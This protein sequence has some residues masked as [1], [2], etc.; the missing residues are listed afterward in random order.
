MIV[1]TGGH[2]KNFNDRTGYQKGKFHTLNLT[3]ST[4][5]CGIQI[6]IENS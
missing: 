4:Y 1:L 2:Q 3:N 6:L 5:Q